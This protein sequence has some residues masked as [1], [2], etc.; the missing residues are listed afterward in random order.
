MSSLHF[1]SGFLLGAATSSYQIEGGW[2]ED[3]KGL[4][5]WDTFSHK[6]G[7]IANDE[8]GD[9]ACDHYHRYNEDISLMQELNLECYR[10]SLSWPRIFPE[11]KG[12]INDKGA[13]FYDKL[14]EGLLDA[15]IE[16]FIT[17]YHWD[18]PA[19]LDTNGGWL[20]RETIDHFVNYARYCFSR[21]GDKVKLWTTFNESHVIS[22]MGYGN[23]AF[24]P[25]LK[26]PKYASQVSHHINIAHAKSVDLFRKMNIKGQIGIVHCLSPVHNMDKTDLCAERTRIIDGFSNRWFTDPSLKGEYPADI[27]DLL[28]KQGTAPEILKEDMDT[29]KNNICDFL[30]IN[31]Y[32][33][34]RVF[35]ND[36][37][38]S[39]FNQYVNIKPVTGAIISEMGWE[40][41]PQG[42]Y[43][44]M[45]RITNN[46]GNI[47]LYV[48]EN[49]MACKDN[50]ITGNYVEDD[51]RLDYLKTHLNMC[52]KAI[53]D[54]VNLKGYLYWSLL[55]NFEWTS[56]Y[57]KKFG[58]IRVNYDTLERTIKKSGRWYADFIGKNSESR[59]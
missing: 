14:I 11:G 50:K 9:V 31:Y 15:G 32:F 13:L 22:N 12:E 16:P 53:D 57:S 41:Y 26:N 24:A 18:L 44:L 38:I 52:K 58:L 17:L 35:H 4:S 7:N 48:T 45:T 6:K 5:I 27:L 39:E 30:G 8:N 46:Y 19:A 10:F 36:S 54:G 25:G 20:N 47:P 28:K 34:F 37:D 2:D 43:E 3:G 33:R 56:G 21:Y 23:G 29:I 1:P 40:V 59:V 51:D 55:D 49:G 42:L